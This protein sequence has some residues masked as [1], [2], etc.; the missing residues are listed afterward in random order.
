MSQLLF[1]CPPRRS[2]HRAADA[3]APAAARPPKCWFSAPAFLV[4]FFFS[5]FYW[6]AYHLSPFLSKDI[7]QRNMAP[8][9]PATPMTLCQLCEAGGADCCSC[10]RVDER[11]SGLR[12]F[13]SIETGLSRGRSAEYSHKQ[14]HAVLPPTLSMWTL[15]LAGVN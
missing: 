6:P 12:T 3:V 13:A 8:P 11:L 15:T 9:S 14:L 10:C 5:F 2:R 4:F 1:L 7:H